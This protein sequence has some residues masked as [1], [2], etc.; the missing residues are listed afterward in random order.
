[1]ERRNFIS[2]AGSL[3]VLLLGSKSVSA[4]SADDHQPPDAG[5]QT[6]EYAAL[7]KEEVAALKAGK[8]AVFGGLA[9]PAELNGYPGPRHTLDLSDELNL[10][11]E[12]EAEIKYLFDDMQSEARLLGKRYLTFERLIEGGFEKGTLTEER[13]ESL[14]TKSG[15]F[16]GEL[17]NTHLKYH[18][19]TKKVL[20][21]EQVDKYNEIR[22]Y[23]NDG[24]DGQSHDGHDGQSTYAGQ[25][26]REYAALSKEEV[27]ALKAGKGTV[28]GGLA[29]PAELNGYPGPRHVLHVSDE[30]NLT[31]EQ[32][33][34][35][36]CL[37]DDMQSEAR[38]LGKEYLEV[39]RQ[40]EDGYEEGTLTEEKLESLLTKS[41]NFY[42]EL[43]NT[44]LKYHFR[45][46]KILTEEQVDKYNEIRGYTNDGHDGDQKQNH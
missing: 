31:D 8:G 5:Q 19:Q 36:E 30:L 11:D 22:G 33:A 45:A 3:G 25:Q 1:M 17:R 38:P 10:T 26:T 42:G 32:E 12:Q 28:F 4:T 15:D 14:L 6:Q 41:G 23:T 27:A 7:S 34:E 13:L 9:K 46:K 39:E 18:F 29:K 16:Y 44:H 20:T 37:F 43:R 35:I 24:H 40:I 2:A 21:E